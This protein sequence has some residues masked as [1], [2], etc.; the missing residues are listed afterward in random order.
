[1]SDQ[2]QVL[3][4]DDDRR[5]VKTISDILRVSGYEAVPAYSGEEAVE[6]VKSESPACVLMDIKMP[7]IDG[8][9]ALKLIRDA[10]PNLPVLL[11]SA[12]VTGEQEEEAKR[13]G[14]YAVLTKPVDIEGILSF[15]SLL[16]KDEN[17]LVVDDD[18]VFSKTLKEI[19]QARG[20]WVETEVD[21]DKVLG[22]MERDYKLMVLLDL[23]PGDAD[24]TD[25]LWAIREK[26]PTK[27]VV[28]VTSYREEMRDSIEK[29]LQIGAY[30]CL[31]KPF[32]TE[33]LIGI[34]EEI[35]QM[36]IRSALGWN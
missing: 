29:G 10:V 12:Y 30:T 21:A 34:I 33:Q 1:M 36:K 27:P 24:G 7:G 8:V 2:L 9:G 20:Y 3:V 32:E 4:V 25:V 11:M 28:M 35:R 26:Y 19:L 17:V 16:R 18:P 14:A 22:H 23:N 15:L 13:Q 6:K 5:M 31:Y